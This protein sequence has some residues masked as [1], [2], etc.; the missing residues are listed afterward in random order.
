MTV[1]DLISADLIAVGDTVTSTNGV[2][3]ATGT[4]TANG[5]VQVDGKPHPTPSAAAGAVKGENAVNGWDFW[6]VETQTGAVTLATLRARYAD[7][8]PGVPPSDT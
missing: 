6:A 8:L 5:G 2:W 3:P 1:K 4:I 7:T